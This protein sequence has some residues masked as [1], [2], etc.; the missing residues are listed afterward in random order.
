[1]PDTLAYCP[2]LPLVL[3]RLRAF[4]VDRPP[5]LVLAAM[6]VPSRV[7]AEF[8][9]THTDGYCPEPDLAERAAFWDDYYAERAGVSDDSVPSVYLSELD[10][11]I[12]GAL[13]GGKVQFM[14]NTE[15]GWISSMVE[16][17][18]HDWAD[19]EGLRFDPEHPWFR[20]YLA[21]LDLFVERARGKFGVSHFILINGLNFVFEL[22]GATRT[23]LA[24]IEAPELVERALDL[25]YEVNL[26]V[27]EAFFA[28]AP[29]LEGGTCSNMLQWAPGR[30]ISD[31]VDPFHMTGVDYFERWGRPV[32]ERMW[33]HFD[34]A[35]LHIHGNGR[36]L[37][38][39]VA[40]VPGLQGIWL[41]DDRG[42]PTAF[43]VLPEIRQRVGNLP[44]IA[45]VPYGQ[46]VAA[47]D[48]HRLTGGVFYNVTGVPDV[49]TA[50]RVMERVRGYRA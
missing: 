43:E 15:T 45:T 35:G 49:E 10:Q 41:G 36:H 48:A 19:F 4:Y 29:R 28:H 37:L 2:D 21:Q 47:L 12:Y 33:R 16:P 44:L 22:V 25:S 13:V 1:M 27:Q 31:S 26:A 9:A 40:T 23:Y 17:I 50:A 7:L 11:A 46:F 3:E 20:R 8:A 24:L 5:D 38:E 39:A 42:F 14:C 34:G 6:H 18:L 30:I 32:L